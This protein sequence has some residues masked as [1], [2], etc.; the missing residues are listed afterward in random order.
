MSDAFEPPGGN[1]P[2][3]ASTWAA[4]F[5][6][7]AWKQAW[8]ANTLVVLVQLLAWTT[9]FSLLTPG[10]WQLDFIGADWAEIGRMYD[11]EYDPI[12]LEQGQVY[13]DGPRIVHL[14]TPGETFLV[15]PD[16]TIPDEAVTAPQ[17]IVVRRD[18]LFRRQA[19]REERMDLLEMQTTLGVPDFRVDG[20]SIQAFGETWGTRIGVGFALFLFVVTATVDAVTGLVYATVIAAALASARSVPF[21]QVFR[22]CLAVA[23][24]AD[25]L[26]ALLRVVGLGPLPCC[27]GLVIWPAMILGGAFWAVPR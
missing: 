25:L 7:A 27:S 4:P 26:H 11:A 18:H 16:L 6:P 20:P 12:R 2:S 24:M 1:A 3:G 23:C 14:E 21:G 15:D 22:V 10:L 19:F 9:L 5:W 13:V 8:N 17:A